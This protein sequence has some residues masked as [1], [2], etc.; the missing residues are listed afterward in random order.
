[1]SNA[2]K[3]V[4]LGLYLFPLA[5]SWSGFDPVETMGTLAPAPH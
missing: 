4:D 2:Q 5:V 1:M 3:P